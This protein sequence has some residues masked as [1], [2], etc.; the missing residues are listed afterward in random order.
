MMRHTEG[1]AM[2]EDTRK[3]IRILD[4]R[5]FALYT[6]TTAAVMGGNLELANEIAAGLPHIKGAVE[7]LEGK[8]TPKRRR[9]SR[10]AA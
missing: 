1:E 8:R 3:A 9:R 10:R 4:A 5:A 6:G 7:F 2:N